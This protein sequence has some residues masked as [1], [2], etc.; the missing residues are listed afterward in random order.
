MFIFTIKWLFF[1]NNKRLI[2]ELE[3]HGKP[4]NVEKLLDQDQEIIL[5]TMED[6]VVNGSTWEK[7]FWI[8]QDNEVIL[9]SSEHS[10]IILDDLIPEKLLTISVGNLEGINP[11]DLFY[12][13]FVE[14]EKDN[15]PQKVTVA[16]RDPYSKPVIL[17]PKSSFG[18]RNQGVVEIFEG[19]ADNLDGYHEKLGSLQM[20]LEGTR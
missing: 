18:I 14:M 17:R 3:T 5:G 6:T 8:E 4:W 16:Y 1:M 11:K 9:G 12:Q 7:K 13:V 20:Y 2:V 15:S 19:V 10:N